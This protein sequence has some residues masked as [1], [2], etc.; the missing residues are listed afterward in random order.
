VAGNTRLRILSS[1]VL[2][3]ICASIAFTTFKYYLVLAADKLVH[4]RF[5]ALVKY[6]NSSCVSRGSVL[7]IGEIA[8]GK[9]YFGEL[10]FNE[11]SFSKLSDSSLLMVSLTVGI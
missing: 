3:S 11:M 5:S 8:I 9:T 6:L 10:S 7:S 4:F 1:L 2:S